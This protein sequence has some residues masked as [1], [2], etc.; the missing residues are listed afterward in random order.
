[1]QDLATIIAAPRALVLFRAATAEIAVARL[2]LAALLTNVRGP[3]IQ[4]A[5]RKS[6]EVFGAPGG[7]I[8]A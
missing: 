6:R 4:V 8:V 2:V 3:T 7:T 1:V 5:D